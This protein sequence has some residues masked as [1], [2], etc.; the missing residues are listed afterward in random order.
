VPI[1]QA[2]VPVAQYG[3]GVVGDGLSQPMQTY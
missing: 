2:G 1:G 3:G